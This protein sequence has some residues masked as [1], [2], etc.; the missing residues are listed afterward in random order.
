MFVVFLQFTLAFFTTQ[1]TKLHCS[2]ILICL[3][4]INWTVF[5]QGT[6]YI[7]QINTQHA[8]TKP[9]AQRNPRGF[10]VEKEM[11]LQPASLSTTITTSNRFIFSESLQF[12]NRAETCWEITNSHIRQR[13][14]HFSLPVTIHLLYQIS[15]L[16][17]FFLGFVGQFLSKASS[18]QSHPT[19]TLLPPL[20][21]SS[22]SSVLN[23]WAYMQGKKRCGGET[24]S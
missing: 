1:I 11:T 24:S 21:L 2:N 16:S 14:D 23:N 19:P 17:F 6:K 18:A 15:R 4:Q 8:E 3:H 5:V 12:Y 13:M 7:L 10:D 22:C 9:C 20:P